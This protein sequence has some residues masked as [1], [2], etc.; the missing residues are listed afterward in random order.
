MKVFFTPWSKTQVKSLSGE[1]F[2]QSVIHPDHFKDA[3]EMG[4]WLVSNE[5]D[6]RLSISQSEEMR[7]IGCLLYS[8]HFINRDNL[9]Q[10][11]IAD[12]SWNSSE[13]DDYG[14]F[15]LSLRN[16]TL[17][18]DTFIRIIFISTVVS[19]MEKMTNHFSSL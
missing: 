16:F 4:E 5:Y 12:E 18:K 15:H 2:I 1:I 3:C 9:S 13:E 14:F 17:D 6:A 11:I 10:A 7:I 19:K 8:H